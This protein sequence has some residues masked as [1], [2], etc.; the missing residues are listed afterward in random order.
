MPSQVKAAVE[1]IFP[2]QAHMINS[3]PIASKFWGII[4]GKTGK[5]IETWTN[6]LA[7]SFGIKESTKA[8]EAVDTAAAMLEG[9][10]NK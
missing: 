9:S 7:G 8:D 4:D 10:G 5:E 1:A 2:Q 3:H 6:N